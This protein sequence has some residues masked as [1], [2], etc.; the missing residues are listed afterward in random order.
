[1]KRDRQLSLA[2]EVSMFKI[3]RRQ[4]LSLEEQ[5][6]VLGECGIRPRT[7]ITADQL[8]QSW[9]R[10]Q[11]EAAPFRLAVV[12]LGGET[13][14]PPFA[15]RSDDV[16]HF[17]T[18]C[19]E[20]HGS[21]VAIAERMRD[22]AQGD[23]PLT[24]ITDYVDIEEGEAWLEFELGGQTLRWEAEVEDDWVDATIL[25]RFAELL[26]RLNTG[27][28]FTYLDLKGQDCILGCCSPDQ[29]AALRKKTGLDFQWLS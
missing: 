27:R 29:L 11:F 6:H 28:R 12:A 25:T 5:L 1:M 20:D 19:I 7:G 14:T 17:D 2:P 9:D 18:E 10:A 15:H 21:Y 13:E 4:T 8:L 22:L 24:A 26:A 23:L 3:F 16:W